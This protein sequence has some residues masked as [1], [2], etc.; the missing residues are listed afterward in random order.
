MLSSITPLGQRGHRAS[1]K[2]TVVG[3]WVGALLAGTATFGL[4]GAVGELV[5]LTGM[6]TLVSV[7]VLGLG[8]VLDG[9]RIDPPGPDR[10]VD[11][12][13]LGRYRDWV[14]GIGFGAQLG[15]GL[16]TIVT[17]YAIWALLL[18][19]A[20]VGLPAALLLGLT[21]AVGRSL[22]LLA[23]SRVNEPAA[24]AGLMSKLAGLQGLSTPV[25]LLGYAVALAG[26]AA[27]V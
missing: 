14:T 9:L 25:L 15:S 26:V 10:Q 6:P 4:A 11:E 20:L 17:V 3:F 12:N 8:A 24:L 27:Y 2:R 19:A 22:P 5:G 13:W 21:F 18:V 16:V 1:W 7:A 23:T